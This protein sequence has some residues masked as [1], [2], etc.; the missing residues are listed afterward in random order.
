MT[1]PG[2]G[3]D[4]VR[5]EPLLRERPWGGS[6]LG[7]ADP[8]I[9]EAWIAFGESRVADGRL[10][11]RTVDALV[12]DDPAGVLGDAVAG[13]F[14]SRFPLLIK[15]LDT[16]DWLSVQVHPTDEQAERLVGPGAWGKTEAWHVLEAAPGASGKVGVRGGISREELAAAIEGGRAHELMRELPFTPGETILVPAGT[17]HTIGPGILLYEVQQASDTTYRAFDWGRS[18][19][20]ERPLH[21][22][23][24]IAVADPDAAPV[25]APPVDLR[26]T[27]VTVVASCRYFRLDLVRLGDAPLAADT[28]RRSFHLLT[29]IEGGAAIRVGGGEVILGTRG[30]ALVPGG[31][32]RYLVSAVGPVAR[33]MRASVPA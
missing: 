33:L 9:G 12:A 23:E 28:E 13:R 21:V 1:G 5:L 2:S 25:I 6:R 30:T 16:A 11:G 26:G 31:A 14:G 29:V 19:G 4:A 32:G 3:P 8:P 20:P 22:V 17:L 18:G 24:S 15:L 10:A 27:S 7:S